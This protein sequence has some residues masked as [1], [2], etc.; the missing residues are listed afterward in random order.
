MEKLNQ[1]TAELME[2]RFGHDNLI[3][4][5]TTAGTMPQVRAVN[6]YYE[7]G[8]F[9][10][11]THAH[12]GKMQQLRDNPN[13]AICGD[14]FS[15]HGIGENLGWIRLPENAV[16]ADKLR[17]AFTEWYGNGHVNEADENTVILRIRLTDGILF[18][19]G[20]RYEIDFTE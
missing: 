6:A 7:S 1:T 20:T 12:S 10:I 8:S 14:W 5:A 15:A 4:L 18:H 16:T 17:V 3:A 9:Y 19:H 11:I 13:A 2:K